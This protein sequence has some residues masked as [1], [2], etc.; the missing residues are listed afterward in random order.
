MET[1]RLAKLDDAFAEVV[2]KVANL[3]PVVY[4]KS[5]NLLSLVGNDP[6]I[7]SR[8]IS[9]CRSCGCTLCALDRGRVLCSTCR[10]NSS[11]M[12]GAPLIKTMYRS[13]HPKYIL[14]KEM[15]VVVAHI[16]HQRDI[17]SAAK[18]VAKQLAYLSYNVYE[19]WRQG[20]GN[21]NVY[22]TKDTLCGCSYETEL[23]NCN[24]RYQDGELGDCYGDDYAECQQRLQ[25]HMAVRVG[26][27]GPKLRDVV[28][29]SAVD[30]LYNM[31]AM[32]RAQFGI[33]LE[34]VQGDS[35]ILNVVE[36][37]SELIANR[38]V[39]ME[40]KI[41]DPTQHL[42]SVALEHVSEMQFVRCRHY[43]ARFANA[44]IRTMRE[45]AKLVSDEEIPLDL[46]EMSR[47]LK[48]PCPELLKSLPTVA[49]DMHFDHL[50]Q[51]LHC[52]KS[53]GQLLESSKP[54]AMLLEWRNSIARGTLCLLLE[55][56]I[57]LTQKW[58]QEP[59]LKCL[60]HDQIPAKKHL[61]AQGWVDNVHIANWSL[62][63]SITHAHRRTGLDETGLRVV[64][65]SS[66]LM[67]I[68]SDERSFVPG[69][70]RCEMMHKV[71]TSH[72]HLSGYSYNALGEQIWPYMTGAPW[73]FAREEVV[74][75]QGSHME[76]DLRRVAADLGGFS[77]NEIFSR[78]TR[79]EGLHTTFVKESR[80][81]IYSKLMSAAANKMVFKPNEHYDQWLCV[82]IQ[83]ALPILTQ[84][85]QSVGISDNVA[86]NP[87]GDV[88]RLLKPVREW[89]P[90][91][92]ILSITAGEAYSIPKVKS[93]LVKLQTEGSPLVKK[94]RI[95]KQMCWVFD[96]KYLVD[97][98]NK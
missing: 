74:N 7:P 23:T 78:F 97:V 38:V 93:T 24:P 75:W 29:Q 87:T 88:L 77:I 53:Q 36:Q 35:T 80:H 18:A 51:I 91:S 95:G 48:K 11:V 6:P 57:E 17:A 13:A 30:W 94:K 54:F 82:S 26:G 22:F 69:V 67:Q 47:F 85:R 70:M 39:L 83:L 86:T 52:V 63:S 76:T 89:K 33:T 15:E 45:L 61:P 62:V 60:R 49:Q 98:L 21:L 56:A 58:K 12:E 65:M 2:A 4:V 40:S 19:R 92:G 31:D 81:N 46:D 84:I 71:C 66:A 16:G 1:D 79:P 9:T 73:K 14:N 72:E 41:D 25:R 59:F 44:D 28:K 68:N 20:L 50:D 37:F 55:R 32:I 42:C 8:S 5:G 64:L 43:A 27:L 96:C 90:S 3:R 10:L 34:R